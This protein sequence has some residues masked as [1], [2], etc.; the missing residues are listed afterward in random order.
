M[1]LHCRFCAGVPTALR[2]QGEGRRVTPDD[3]RME[4]VAG[5]RVLRSAGRGDRAR[6]LLGFDD[7]HTV[8]LKVTAPDDPGAALEI[9]ALGRAAGEHVVA[10]DDVSVDENRTVL[11]LERLP[12]GT[13]AELLERRT[14]LDAG[15]A[16]TVLAPIAATL[17]RIHTAGVS[18]GQLSLAAICFR[19]D[20]APT[21]TGFGG[22][23]LFAPETPEVVR[24]T[25]PG[26]LTDRESL[27]GI[28]GIVL[29]RVVG[30]RAEVARGLATAIT[31]ASPGEIAERLFGLATATPVRFSDEPDDGGGV[32]ARMGE[33]REPEPT[34][35][36]THKVLPPWLATLLPE[37]I[38]E[39]VDGPVSRV[40]E[41]WAGWEVRRRRLVLGALAGGLTVMVAVALVPAAPAAS[42]VVAATPTPPQPPVAEA[43]LPDDP[44]EAVVLLLEQRDRCLRDLS[45]LC[46]D[47]VVQP[48]SAAQAD[49]VALIR[50]VQAGA[51]YP[52]G[53]IA[54]GDPVLVELLGDA[55]LLDLPPGS[56]PTSVLLMRTTNGWRIRQYV[57]N[58]YPD[59]PAVDD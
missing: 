59:A 12:N 50:G 46:L 31:D 36:A 1:V 23:A 55:A 42:I 44:V 56:R 49:D 16:V 45:L 28:A 32:T 53:G 17:D 37:W 57:D 39:R 33:L 51:E 41:V 30:A 52:E 48:N 8:V 21:I 6:L 20:G 47:E 43:E 24:E 25:V 29:G 58:Q 38:R 10:L 11:V 54:S 19:E 7:G 3:R 18:H 27:R 9:D 26:V 13:L 22:A 35:D 34:E 14:A 2:A 15:E 4:D 5:Y 40:V